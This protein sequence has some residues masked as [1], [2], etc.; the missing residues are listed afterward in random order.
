MFVFGGLTDTNFAGY[1]VSRL[2]LVEDDVKYIKNVD[3]IKSFQEVDR[4]IRKKKKMFEIEKSANLDKV[5]EQA[6][7]KS[8]LRHTDSNDRILE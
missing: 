1:N 4:E 8:S 3:T 6:G 7:K 5:V 2:E